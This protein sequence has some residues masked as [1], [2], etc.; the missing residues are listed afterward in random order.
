[1]RLPIIMTLAAAGGA[2][3][4]AWT[5][6]EDANQAYYPDASGWYP[7]SDDMTGPLLSAASSAGDTVWLGLANVSAW[8]S[9]AG[10]QAGGQTICPCI[11]SA[12]LECA[13]LPRVARGSRHESA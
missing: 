2:A 4:A 1:M 9:H 10:E 11:A 8:Q 5:I 6:D 3:T 13:H 12:G 7:R